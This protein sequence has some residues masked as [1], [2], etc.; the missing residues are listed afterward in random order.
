MRAKEYLEI[1]KSKILYYDIVKSAID[2]LSLLRNSKRKTR[3][4]FNRYLFADARFLANEKE[5]VLNAGEVNEKLAHDVRNSIM[6]AVCRDE[7]FVFAYNIIAMQE[8]VY[9]SLTPL[10]FCKI[11]DLNSNTVFKIENI[12]RL[13]KEDYP[14]NNLMDFLLEDDNSKFY[15]KAQGVLNKREQWWLKVFNEAYAIFDKMRLILHK[16]FEAKR[17]ITQY[18]NEDK[19]FENTVVDLVLC[20][21]S[22]YDYDLNEKQKKAIDLLSKIIYQHF[23]RIKRQ[24]YEEKII[25]LKNALKEKEEE[26]QINI[27]SKEAIIEAQSKKIKSLSKDIDFKN[28]SLTIPQ[29]NLFYYYIFNE[30]GVNFQ[31]SKKKDWA[32]VISAMNGKNEEYIR[33][34]LS[35]NFDDDVTKNDMRIVISTIDN[36]FPNITQKIRNDIE[37]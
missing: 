10:N 3:E 36:L 22:R 20:L 2:V 16:P 27:A 1:N 4:Y 15:Y 21:I 12:C 35:I 34:A 17:L 8:N 28:K 11:K 24:S 5:F 13:Y 25:D 6:N 31:N 37:I 7:S 23:S 30:L 29:Q 18:K 14:K 19:D 33:K 26:Y 32:K 9:Y